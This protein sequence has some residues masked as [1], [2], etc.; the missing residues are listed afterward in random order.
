MALRASE[1]EQARARARARV[2]DSA[3]LALGVLLL[4]L[5]V[6]RR[7]PLRLAHERCRW[8][9]EY[10]ATRRGPNGLTVLVST[11]VLRFLARAAQTADTLCWR[12]MIIGI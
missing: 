11:H 12:W 10:R 8:V 4:D 9:L 2:C 5:A 6:Q 3:D 7:E 1:R